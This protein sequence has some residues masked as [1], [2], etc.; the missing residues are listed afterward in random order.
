LAKLW[1]KNRATNN[2]AERAGPGGRRESLSAMGA[3]NIVEGVCSSVRGG[4]SPKVNSK[5]ADVAEK[6]VKTPS[7][8]GFSLG[9]TGAEGQGAAWK[10]TGRK[11]TETGGKKG[12]VAR[13]ERRRLSTSQKQ[14]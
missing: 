5:T 6:L 14:T 13:S 4:E 7:R 12:F 10:K 3:S 9:L 1:E 2:S 11:K 8:N